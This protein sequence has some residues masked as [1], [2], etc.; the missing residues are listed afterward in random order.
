MTK[1][2]P[3]K[4]LI[5][6]KLSSDD[7]S[8][9]KPNK[10]MTGN[11]YALDI[12]S[13][14]IMVYRGA[15]LVGDGIEFISHDQNQGFF[16]GKKGEISI[17]FDPINAR[18]FEIAY[19]AEFRPDFIVASDGTT[20]NVEQGI[21]FAEPH[22]EK[23]VV[24]NGK[25]EINGGI[26]LTENPNGKLNLTDRHGCLLLD[27]CT[28]DRN[29]KFSYSSVENPSKLDGF[30]QVT[31]FEKRKLISEKTG[32]V[33]YETDAS[34]IVSHHDAER[35]VCSMIV[36]YD[37]EAKTSVVSLF[38]KKN[39]VSQIINV[40]GRAC[41]VR[42]D[43]E[44]NEPVIQYATT[45]DTGYHHCNFVTLKGEDVTQKIRKQIDDEWEH[46][47]R[48]GE[49]ASIE[50]KRK[51]QEENERENDDAARR[52]ETTNI[53]MG[54]SLMGLGMPATGATVIA[55]SSIA[56]YKREKANREREEG[57]GASERQPNDADPEFGDE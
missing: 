39:V 26:H 53:M 34:H 13:Q 42:I 45:E 16:V 20:Y 10:K 27:S 55:A 30:Y 38:E 46:Y 29:A 51:E 44:T 1:F 43:P 2:Y 33:F 56:R 19:C 22:P 23:T 18:E 52:H 49:K 57:E 9:K 35:G 14:G 28:T 5:G 50:A 40:S 11:T 15:E 47:R 7:E 31:E 36:D 41:R 37:P 12:S 21:I 25:V 8:Y 32:K 17:C 24:E 6:Y 54:A 48:E 3:K 4:G